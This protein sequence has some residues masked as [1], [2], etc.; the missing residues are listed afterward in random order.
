MDLSGTKSKIR[1]NDKV[2]IQYADG[3]VEY[4]VKR[5]KVKEQVES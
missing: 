5:K 2:T 1:P 3:K 4:G